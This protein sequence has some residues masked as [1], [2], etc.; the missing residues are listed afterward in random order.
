MNNFFYRHRYKVLLVVVLS[1]FALTLTS[2]RFDAS[3]WYTKVY[4]SYGQEWIDSWNG[5][6]GF[7]NFRSSY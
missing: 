4:T 7:F 1:V 6:S 2:C 5:G 3:A